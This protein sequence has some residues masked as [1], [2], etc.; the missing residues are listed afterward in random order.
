M[1]LVVLVLLTAA[2]L[3]SQEGFKGFPHIPD[4]IHKSSRPAKV[5][6]MS[7]ALVALY[8]PGR[9]MNNDVEYYTSGAG[10]VPSDNTVLL[11]YAKTDRSTD[12]LHFINMDDT[13]WNVD[14][15]SVRIVSAGSDYLRAASFSEAWLDKDFII[16]TVL[17][18]EDG[19]GNHVLVGN[20]V[21]S[22]DNFKVE[23]YSGVRI[24]LLSEVSN[25]LVVNRAGTNIP[26]PDITTQFT[27]V[28][29]S[30]DVTFYHNKTLIAND[31]TASDDRTYLTGNLIFGAE[32]GGG[33]PNFNGEIILIA[34]Y[35]WPKGTMPATYKAD[36]IDKIYDNTLSYWPGN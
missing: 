7:G 12:D 14:S 25:V 6:T 32:S 23:Q 5:P 35:Q 18:T 33:S 34:I 16:S 11:N 17:I 21:N 26:G 28:R 3:F 31:Q 27:V 4:V 15:N 36:I 24:R 22:N 19:S 8:D 29:S 10:A 20:W 9:Q 13:A 30:G 1:R 2:F